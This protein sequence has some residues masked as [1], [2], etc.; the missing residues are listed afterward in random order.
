MVRE[1]TKDFVVTLAKWK[2]HAIQMKFLIV[3]GSHFF[4]ELDGPADLL[5]SLDENDR[6]EYFI[7]DEEGT[8]AHSFFSYYRHCK[9][10]LKYKKIGYHS[11]EFGLISGLSSFIEEELERACALMFQGSKDFVY[12]EHGWWNNY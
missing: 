4:L 7:R 5:Y 3:S 10:N 1:F 8:H 6:D 2:H 9:K 12:R 11:Q